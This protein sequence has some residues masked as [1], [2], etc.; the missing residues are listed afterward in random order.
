MRNIVYWN[1]LKGEKDDDKM[2]IY[3][4]SHKSKEEA[5][6]SFDAFRKDPDWAA[7]RKASEEKGGGSLTEA[8]G[9]VV[10]EFL[11]PTNYSPL[12]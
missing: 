6:K 1:V 8:K 7:A 10:F 2:L 9:G 11:K 12:K 4:L 5:A 3:L